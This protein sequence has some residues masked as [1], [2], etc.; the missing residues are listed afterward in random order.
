MA[1]KRQ[2][3]ASQV[4]EALDKHKG[5]VYLAAQALGC[6]HQTVYNY[7]NRYKSVQEAIDRN[8]GEV[9][10][11]AELSLYNAILNGEHWAI[12]F[13]LKTIGKGRGYAERT[14]QQV[15]GAD[16]GPVETVTHVNVRALDDDELNTLAE[17]ARRIG[18]HPEGEGQA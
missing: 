12:T 5:M 6:S 17:I 8:R 11:T 13:A 2:Y 3:T 9:L 14:E 10:D 7:A 1:G 15:T 18:G 16:G 4:V